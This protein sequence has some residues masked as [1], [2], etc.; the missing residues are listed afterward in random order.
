MNQTH[1]VGYAYGLWP[2]VAV[3]VALFVGFLLSFA[4][5]DTK[6]EWRS[7]GLFTSFIVALFVEM[8]GFPLTIYFLASWLGNKYPVA[9]P[10][11]HVNGH[12]LNV[13]MGIRSDHGSLL[14]ILSN[15]LIFAGG[16]LIVRGWNVVH[17]VKEGVAE[18][19]PYAYVRHPQYLGFVSVIIG[20]LIQ[21]PT[22][23]T[24]LMAPVLIIRYVLL[25]YR[26]EKEMLSKYPK[27]YKAYMEK[28]PAWI[29]MWK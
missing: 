19:G 13:F 10:F 7:F 4:K 12:L 24:L 9:D 25:A 18:Q 22:F 14:H 27:E 6:I 3:N 15:V 20:F 17:A 28:V 23:V 16:V 29:P 11:S 5:P 2:L 26:E 1:A 8:Y 21:W